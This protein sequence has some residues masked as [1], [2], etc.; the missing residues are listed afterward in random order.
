MKVVAYKTGPYHILHNWK[1]YEYGYKGVF[2]TQFGI[3]WGAVVKEYNGRFS[4]YIYEPPLDKIKK[5]KYGACFSYRGNG[6][7]LFNF[8]IPPKDISSGILEIENILTESLQS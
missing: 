4:F 1:A 5:H 7:Y 2:H 6:W 8:I 3:W